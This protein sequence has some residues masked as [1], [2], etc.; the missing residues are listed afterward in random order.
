VRFAGTPIAGVVLVEI[1]PVVDDRGSFARIWAE[2]EL[3]AHGLAARLSQCSVSRNRRAGTLRGMHFQHTPH[4]EAKLVRCTRGAIYDVA[5]DL[6][7]E[8]PTLGCWYAAEL[9]DAN[10]SALYI[11]EGCAHGF[12]TLVEDTEVLYLISAPYV[13]AAA[14]G[15]R[16]DDP[17]FGI[18][19]PDAPERTMSERDRS[20][21]DYESGGSRRNRGT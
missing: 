16:W 21:R 6:R 2:E 10:G 14:D 1:E 13:P 8:S 12:Q 7:P 19:W 17:A 18:D 11:P 3:S 4:E 9:S 15:V 5:L 20:W